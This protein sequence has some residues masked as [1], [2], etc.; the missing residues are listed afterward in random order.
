MAYQ[1]LP[2][3]LKPGIVEWNKGKITFDNG[4]TIT[5]EA[6]SGNSGRGGSINVLICDEF[7]FLKPGIEE[8]FMNSVFPT[9][10][11]SKTSKIIIVSTPHGMGNTF[12]KIYSK[13]SLDL[14]ATTTDPRRKWHHVRVDWWDVPGRDE[15]WKEQQLE[16]MGGDIN[17]FRSGISETV[18]WD[19]LRH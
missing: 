18:F 10:S 16:T 5:A 3:W 13:A 8:E 11:S 17:K 7:A 19:Q 4:C 12:Y 15:H 14:D 9:V 2:N 1:E 6:T